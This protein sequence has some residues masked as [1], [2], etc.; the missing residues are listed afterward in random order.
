MVKKLV[1]HTLKEYVDQL[2]RKTPAPGGGSAVALNAALG[3]ALLEMVT[4]Y[5]VAKAR[6]KRLETR[7]KTNLTK[8]KALR[9]RL[10]ELVDLD[11]KAYEG[12]VKARKKG[13]AEQR[14]AAKAAAAVPKEICQKCYQAMQLTS[15]LAEEGNQN[16]I[17]DLEIAIDM[18]VG[19]FNG[20]LL[21]QEMNS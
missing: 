1:S 12:F 11:A 17:S 19:S 7:F 21:L 15:L 8:C 2:A 20:A 5:S 18:L 14:K 10:L 9:Q 4:Q 13:K 3:V 16:L 6:T